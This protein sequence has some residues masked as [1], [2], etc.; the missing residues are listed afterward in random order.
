MRASLLLILSLAVGCDG[1]SDPKDTDGSGTT[2]T[3]DTSNT[4]EE[5]DFSHFVNT[6]S[7]YTGDLTCNGSAPA[8]P[9]PSC[10]VTH[11]LQGVVEDFQEGSG[12]PDATIK[13]WLSDDI[14]TTADLNATGDDDGNFEIEVPSCT[15]LGYVTT[16]PYGDTVDTY[17]VHQVWD[18]ESNHT[19]NETVN[20]VSAGTAAVI[21]SIIGITWDDTSTGIIAGTAF[22]C[23]EDPIGHAQVYLHDSAGNAPATGEVFYFDDSDFP[24]DNQSVPDANPNNGL[25]VAINVPVGVW[26]AEMWGWNGT[27][28]EQLGATQLEIKVGSVNI[29]NIYAGHTDGV[30]YPPSCLST[31]E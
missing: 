5:R 9:D 10:Q 31:C 18:Y 30:A 13:F 22:D 8:M 23:N 12:V 25:W 21:P 3:S 16:T 19:L 14:S 4:G 29:S 20:S 26:T 11:T 24:A 27:E 1:G 15:P 28:Y 7:A 2:D 6:T 17:E